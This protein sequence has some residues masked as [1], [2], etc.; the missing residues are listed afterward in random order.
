MRVNRQ[1][2][3]LSFQLLLTAA[4]FC[5]CRTVRY[6]PAEKVIETKT[7]VLE[8]VRDTTV[9]IP[10]DTA[11]LQALFECDSTG[12]VLIKQVEAL[13]GKLQA[14]ARILVRDSIVVLDCICDSMAIYLQVKDRYEVV[15]TASAEVRTEYTERALRWWQ[16]A[17]MW[18]GG[19]AAMTVVIALAVF[20]GRR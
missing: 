6:V 3:V 10:A 18:A 20:V 4:C 2:L 19:L 13:H 15:T 1:F 12:K 9:Y 8:V 7:E 14:K 11:T 5:G 16:K 17:L